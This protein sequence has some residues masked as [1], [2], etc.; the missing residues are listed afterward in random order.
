MLRPHTALPTLGLTEDTLLVSPWPSGG[1]SLRG[2]KHGAGADR[3]W[4]NFFQ[5][6]KRCSLPTNGNSQ[7]RCCGWCFLNDDFLYFGSDPLVR[8]LDDC[9]I[10]NARRFIVLTNSVLF[11]AANPPGGQ[12]VKIVCPILQP[13][14]ATRC[15]YAFKAFA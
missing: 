9:P 14:F 12:D 8:L 5:G 15:R 3:R 13:N 11:V 6:Y 2:S 7:K 4:L 10:R 1:S